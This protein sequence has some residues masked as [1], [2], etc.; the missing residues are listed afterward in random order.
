V[1]LSDG[2]LQSVSRSLLLN[3]AN[4]AAVETQSGNW[5]LLQFEIAEEIDDGTWRLGSLLRGQ[6]GT[7]DL[8]AVGAPAGARFVLLDDA[9]VPAGLRSSEIGLEL[10]WRVGPE[11][12]VDERNFPVQ[13]AVGGVR[14]RRHL[15]PVHLGAVTGPGGIRLDWKRS[16]RFRADSWDGE[17]IPLDA[18]E[19]RYRLEIRNGQGAILASA[20]ATGPNWLWPQANV[21]A[22]FGSANPVFSLTVRQTSAEYGAGLAATRDFSF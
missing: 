13:Q 21:L 12:V 22:A 1:E 9:V 10:N 8:A 17:D 5:E 20:D 2:E 7:S 4:L 16:G 19:E 6:G 15:A 3:G 11:G 14:A 18:S